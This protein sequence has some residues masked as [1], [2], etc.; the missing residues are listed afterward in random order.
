MTPAVSRSA[1]DSSRF[2]IEVAKAAPAS[3][4]EWAAALAWG[5]QN[6]IAL[7]IARID[8]ADLTL[9]QQMEKDGAFLTDALVRFRCARLEPARER[10]GAIAVRSAGVGDAAALRD[11]AR[12]SFAGYVGHYHADPRLERAAC[13]E[14]YADWAFRA[15]TDRGVADEVL[16]AVESGKALGFA[17]L[18][19]TAPEEADGMLFGVDP[20][21]RGRGVYRSLLDAFL[22]WSARR[23]ARSAVYSTQLANTTA[24]RAVARIGFEPDRAFLTFHKWFPRAGGTGAGGA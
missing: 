6:G 20:A 17:A 5:A 13:D 10:R 21:A 1:I 4:G 23:G 15:C 24:Q 8:A 18:R 16:L 7:L 12:R 11:L 3:L 22:A 14:T 19:I 9:A 2:G